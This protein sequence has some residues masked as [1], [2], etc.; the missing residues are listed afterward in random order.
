MKAYKKKTMQVAEDIIP[1]SQIK[2]QASKLLNSVHETGRSV[3][4]TQNGKPAAVVITPEEF[5]RLH[6]RDSFVV[7]VEEGRADAKA[8][9]VIETLELEK[10]FGRR[11]G[12]HR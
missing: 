11:Y 7:A 10:N 9:R 6:E 3:V 4:I 1:L 8:G 5:D 2:V 12:K